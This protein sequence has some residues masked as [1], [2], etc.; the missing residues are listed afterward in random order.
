M[1]KANYVLDVV[2]LILFLI[3]AA[4][5]MVKYWFLGDPLT[6]KF[7]AYSFLGVT[8]YTWSVWHDVSG[9]LLLITIAVHLA[10]HLRWM[11][12][13][14]RSLFRRRVTGKGR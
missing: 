11:Y 10:L 8:K 7:H 12:A 13:T 14:T 2:M 5:G 6:G 3:M 9:I 4:T 1:K